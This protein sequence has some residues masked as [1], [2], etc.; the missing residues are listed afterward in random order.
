MNDPKLTL[1]WFEKVDIEH[2]PLMVWLF[3]RALATKDR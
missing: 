3:A 2:Q 1:R